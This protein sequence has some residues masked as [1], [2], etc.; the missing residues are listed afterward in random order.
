M[1]ALLVLAAW[2]GAASAQADC[3]A[4]RI[5]SPLAGDI[6]AGQVPILGS[7]SIEGFQ[8]YKL[9]WAAQAQP[10]TWSAVSSTIDR[11]LR[12]GQLDLWNSA[13]LPDGVYRLKLTAVDQEANERCRFLVEP[14]W[15]ANESEPEPTAS[16]SPPPSPT[17]LP[18]DR[19]GDD[20][21]AGEDSEDDQESEAGVAEE[22]SSDSEIATD[23][24]ET[25]GEEGGDDGSGDD[26]TSGDAQGDESETDESETDDAAGSEVAPEDEGEPSD[27]SDSDAQASE[28]GSAEGQVVEDPDGPVA[29]LRAMAGSAGRAFGATL[30]VVLLAALAVALRGRRGAR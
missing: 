15:L 22:A 30:L 11:P 18:R 26:Q 6:L 21:E 28:D 17:A 4:V 12:N 24:E 8:F 9:E 27:A 25:T 5:S 29:F 10:E 20:G 14:L 19:A 7:A 2:P 16:P 23:S 1:L 13:A 3:R